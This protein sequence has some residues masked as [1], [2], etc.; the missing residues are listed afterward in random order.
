MRLLYIFPRT[1]PDPAL[2]AAEHGRR[3]STLQA[4]ASVGTTV[5]LRELEGAPPAIESIRDGYAV[6]SGIIE[7]AQALEGNYDAMI[8]GCF[9]DPAVDGAIEGTRIP[10]VG[11]ALPAMAASLLLGHQFAVLSPTASAAAQVRTMV[12]GSGLLSRYAGAVPIGLGVRE[13]A[14]DPAQTLDR[15]YDAACRALDLG[16]DVLI[17]GCLS[18][19]FTDAGDELQ[20]RLG[21]PVVNPLRVA[22][23]ACELLVSARLVPSRRFAGT[24]AAETTVPVVS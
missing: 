18:L 22:V 7:L 14:A 4:A 13:F 8:V 3:R 10:V 15:A 19:A 11:C 9:G 2:R 5:D 1:T 6:A 20:A 24:S 17:L 21:I 12:M 23:R 16:A